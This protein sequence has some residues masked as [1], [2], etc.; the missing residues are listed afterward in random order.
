MK[1][2]S[3]WRIGT[4]EDLEKAQAFFYSVRNEITPP[5]SSYP[6]GIQGT[7][8]LL[9]AEGRLLLGIK[10]KKI[11]GLLGYF[12]GIPKLNSGG[13]FDYSETKTAYIYCFV[14]APEHRGPF[15][16]TLLPVLG[17][18]IIADG[19][20]EA[21]FKAFKENNKLINRLYRQYG[22]LVCEEANMQGIMSNVYSGD[23]FSWVTKFND[24][25]DAVHNA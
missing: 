1:E 6:H 18:N 7:I 11:V 5:F 19:H 20:V 8:E 23:P 13:G 12:H 17:K 14:I 2:S 16:F 15:S 3:E 22:R 24:E 25:K 21:R 9:L 4:E 10:D